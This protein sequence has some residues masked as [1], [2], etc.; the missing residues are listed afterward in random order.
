MRGGYKEHFVTPEAKY[1]GSGREV[2][3]KGS[4]TGDICIDRN[5]KV[6][7]CRHF[8][9]DPIWGNTVIKK[10]RNS[11]GEPSVLRKNP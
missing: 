7:S 3:G 4:R 8:A 9:A 11:A 10:E 6:Y 1:A 5:F 2:A